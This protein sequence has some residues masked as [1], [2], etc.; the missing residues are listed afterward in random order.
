MNTAVTQRIKDS[1]EGKK[2]LSEFCA[3]LR[4]FRFLA[5]NLLICQTV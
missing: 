1:V 4:N 2:W 3:L 5:E